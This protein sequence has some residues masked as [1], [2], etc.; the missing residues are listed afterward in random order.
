MCLG[1]EGEGQIGC[2]SG[3]QEVIS[4]KDLGE[5]FPPSLPCAPQGTSSGW[6]PNSAQ[7]PHAWAET[8]AGAQGL[9]D[10]GWRAWQVLQEEGGVLRHS[11]S[12]A[13]G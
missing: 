12:A 3:K 4:L 10:G 6:Q 5:F 7:D 9:R 13:W 2:V 11:G 1:D 8:K